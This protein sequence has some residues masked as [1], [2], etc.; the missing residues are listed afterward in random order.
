MRNKKVGRYR[1]GVKTRERILDT[2]LDLIA[3]NGHSATSIAKISKISTAAG[4]QLASRERREGA[5]ALLIAAQRVRK[6]ARRAMQQ[7][8]E[9]FIL[10]ED[11]A[12]RRAIAEEITHLV[13]MG[14]D[15]VF[16]S[17]QGA[18]RETTRDNGFT[19]RERLTQH[20]VDRRLSRSKIRR[21]LPGVFS[22]T[23]IGQHFS[24]RSSLIGKKAVGGLHRLRSRSDIGHSTNSRKL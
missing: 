3:S 11:A 6:Q 17:R 22:L 1:E 20:H 9:Q 8:V 15:G 2:T 5:P 23:K 13:M 4:V 12:P 10:A 24:D 7:R 18:V 21:T 19:S 16:V 14:L